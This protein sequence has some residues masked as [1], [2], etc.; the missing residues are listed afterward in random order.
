MKR[1]W[2]EAKRDV[3]G[4]LRAT[5]FDGVFGHRALPQAE[6]FFKT[7]A[8][9]GNAAAY[10]SLIQDSVVEFLEGPS[11]IY[12]DWV[13]YKRKHLAREPAHT[14]SWDFGKVVGW[15]GFKT[16]GLDWEKIV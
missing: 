11:G 4:L 1:T 15:S 7:H 9:A 6:G 2:Q 3:E 13:E 5:T 12:S 14:C 10:W 8:A 16:G